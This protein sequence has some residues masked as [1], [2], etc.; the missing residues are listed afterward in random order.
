VLAK[1]IVE[2][3]D[4]SGTIK[5]SLDFKVQDFAI[6]ALKEQL[7]S[8]KNQNVHDGAVLVLETKTGRV[9]AYVANSGSGSSSA[10]QVDG[11]KMRRQAGSTIKP[12]VYATAFERNILTPSSL[13]EDSP[14]DITVSPGKIYHPRN[15]DN[16][17]RG[18]VG[19]AD[20]L[21][22]SMNVPAV[23]A[24][25][26]VGDQHV[27]EKLNAIGFNNLQDE[28]YYGPSLALGSID[29][30]LWEL[31]HGYRHFALEDSPFSKSTRES[32]F[33]ILALPEYRRH[34]FGMDSILTLPFPAAVKTGTSKDMRD[35]WCVGWTPEY[36]VGVWVGNFNGDPMWNVSGVT[37]AAPIWRALML[38]LNKTTIK[39]AMPRY[40]APNQP[41]IKRTLSRIRYPAPATLVGIDPDI[42]ENLQKLPIEIENPQQGHQIF[43]DDGIL[44]D[45]RKITM[46]PL[47]RG[48]HR[49][50]LKD[51]NGYELDTV[52]IE[53]R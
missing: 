53:V 46:W 38:S 32:I 22:S 7:D 26:L 23:R 18:F 34:T 43:L 13:L 24:L 49:I 9:A 29:V 39:S 37:G 17:F 31:A 36:T 44:G 25:Q 2:A 42:P 15:Y 5:T 28:D 41:L 3:K 20:A 12:F 14:A 6:H 21:G 51:K 33:N 48:P 1:S 47:A 52:T 11:V 45:S 19:V 40:Q 16:V 35:N 8:L 4:D 50:S 27:L 10:P 30:S